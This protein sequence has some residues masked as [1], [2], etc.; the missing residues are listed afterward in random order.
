MRWCPWALQ[1]GDIEA[2][3]RTHN[4]GPKYHKAFKTARYWRKIR[5][6]MNAYH[7][8]K[9]PHLRIWKNKR[10]AEYEYGHYVPWECRKVLGFVEDASLPNPLLQIASMIS[11]T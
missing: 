9:H 5:G 1:F 6:E 3:A 11:S 4:G 8:D 10:K 2:L 7:F